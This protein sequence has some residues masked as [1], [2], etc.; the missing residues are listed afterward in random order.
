MIYIQLKNEIVKTSKKE[1]YLYDICDILYNE[2]IQDFKIGDFDEGKSFFALSAIKVIEILQ[3][4]YSNETFQIIGETIVCV[5]YIKPIKPNKFIERVKV[6]FIGSIIFAGASTAL[7]AFQIE[8][9]ID[10]LVFKY[11]EVFGVS[12]DV[13]KLAFSIPYPIGIAL[14]II[15]FFN[16]F[17]NKKLNEDPT[18][19][20][21][22]MDEFDEKVK[23]NIVDKLLNEN[24]GSDE[25]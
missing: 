17:G 21:I 7:M 9:N 22:E 15:V 13:S 6:F 23:V 16:H 12:E 18:P 2:G 24:K 20:E 25:D 19:I 3:K 8:S 5:E 10:E 4:K 11:A 1:I 14:G